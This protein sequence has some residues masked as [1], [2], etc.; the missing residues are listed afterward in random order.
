MIYE[1]CCSID[2]ELGKVAGDHNTKCVRMSKEN[3]NLFDHVQIKNLV[4]QKDATP[5]CHLHASLPCTVLSTWQHMNCRKK[6]VWYIN[7]LEERRKRSLKM[8]AHFFP[9]AKTSS[10]SCLTVS[11]LALMQS[12]IASLFVSS[13]NLPNVTVLSRFSGSLYGLDPVLGV[14]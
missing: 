13:G 6:G 5:G 11:I 4:K 14:V 12:M 9:N 3:A 10:V 8:F 2:S 7:W 1:F